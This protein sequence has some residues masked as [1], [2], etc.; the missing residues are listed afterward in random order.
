MA[1]SDSLRKCT[2][3]VE[4]T[5]TDEQVSRLRSALTGA[6]MTPA[7]SEFVSCD[8]LFQVGD[9][10]TGWASGGRYRVLAVG[11][12]QP[13]GPGRFRQRVLIEEVA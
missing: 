10:F 4:V 3:A 8:R 1:L 6:L 13:T 5:V 2:G 9:E 7:Q 12:P 11:K